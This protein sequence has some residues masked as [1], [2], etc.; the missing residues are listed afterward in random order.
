MNTLGVF[1]GA[2]GELRESFA[3]GS[4]TEVTLPT[5]EFMLKSPDGNSRKLPN[6]PTKTTV[7]PFDSV[8]IWSVVPTVAT[9]KSLE[10]FAVNL[11]NKS[12]SDLRANEALPTSP[13]AQEAGLVSGFGGRPI[14][15]YLTIVGLVL[16]VL[17]WYLY[18]RRWIS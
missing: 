3:T 7:G 16:M 2:S 11:M 5:G 18:Q 13:S 4:T 14:W 8:G 12:S 10:E 6:G 17:E 1:S 15:W 9:A